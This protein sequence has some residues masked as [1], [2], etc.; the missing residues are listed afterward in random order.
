LGTI[1]KTENAGEKWTYINSGMDTDFIKVI[2]NKTNPLLGL[3]TGKNGTILRTANGGL[4]FATVNS[5]TIHSI[6]GIG[7]RVNSN[8]VDA[9]ASSG[10][11]ISSTNS[12]GSWTLKLAG[13]AN[14]YTGIQFTTEQRGYI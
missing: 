14:D 3:V 8:Y 12:G 11:L 9:V 6:L 4:T 13:R 7:F 10:V 5:R 2:F 1:I